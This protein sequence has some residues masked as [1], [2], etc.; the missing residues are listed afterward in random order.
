MP[1]RASAKRYARAMFELG[2]QRGQV[3]QLGDD[4]RM[5]EQALQNEQLRAFLEH[6]KV[7]LSRKSQAIEEVLQGADPLIRNLLSLLVSRGLVDLVP[8]VEREYQQL[9]DELRGRERVQVYAAVPLHDSEKGR[10]NRFL[11]DLI[12]R[13]VVLDSQVDPSILGGLIIKIGD[14]LV[15]GST[16]TRL[17]TL[18]KQLQ[19]ASHVIE[20]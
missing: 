12:K 2:S 20:G 7:P 13:E 6:A 5:A 15:D 19:K 8:E 4:L 17:E 11:A 16:R 18:G 3:D 14:R 10:I 9:L 1:R